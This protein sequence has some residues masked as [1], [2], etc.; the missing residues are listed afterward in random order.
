MIMDQLTYISQLH[1]ETKFIKVNAE[2]SE[3]L[4]Q[5][6]KI[7]VMPSI[8]LIQDGKT[9]KTLMGLTEFDA[10]GRGKIITKD[11]ELVLFN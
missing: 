11:V 4:V 2:K 6:L 1:K 8:V 3:Y 10:S 9:E 5:K 7:C